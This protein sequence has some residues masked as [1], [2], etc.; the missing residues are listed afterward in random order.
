MVLPAA[1]VDTRDNSSL[2]NF[3]YLDRRHKRL[4]PSARR[5]C[6]RSA[7]LRCD[8]QPLR[9]SSTPNGDSFAENSKSTHPPIYSSRSSHSPHT[10]HD[11]VLESR[12]VA[13]PPRPGLCCFRKT[14]YSVFYFEHHTHVPYDTAVPRIDIARRSIRPG[15][16]VVI[17]NKLIVFGGCDMIR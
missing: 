5:K 4:K 16:C 12:V 7:S 2:P 13:Q 6:A 14:V 9:R 10:D 1:A 17:S 8:K 3:F 11:R 15:F